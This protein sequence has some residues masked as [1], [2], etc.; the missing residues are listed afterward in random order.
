MR[1]SGTLVIV[2]AS[3]GVW[4]GMLGRCNWEARSVSTKFPSTPESTSTETTWTRP[5]KRREGRWTG[6][7]VP[8]PVSVTTRMRSLLLLKGSGPSLASLCH[9]WSDV[10]QSEW[11]ERQVANSPA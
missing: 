3:K 1:L 7:L 4:R 6:V 11:N 2:R 10:S 9:V 8:G 5:L